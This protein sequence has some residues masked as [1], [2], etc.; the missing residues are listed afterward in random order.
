MPLPGAELAEEGEVGIVAVEI[1]DV[2]DEQGDLRFQGG[3]EA[4]VE[5]GH[6]GEGVEEI[7]VVEI[8]VVEREVA[9]EAG[10]VA[11]H[12][13]EGG[14]ELED[15]SG[16]G[17]EPGVEVRLQV[18]EDAVEPRG[19]GRALVRAEQAGRRREL[20]DD[21]ELL[22]EQGQAGLVGI[23]GRAFHSAGVLQVRAE[24]LS[25]VGVEG[26]GLRGSVWAATLGR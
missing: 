11:D 15:P 7:S 5:L 18:L 8:M 17:V 2:V 20:V 6:G 26:L 1:G 10:G 12:G 3:D 22:A 21:D 13:I 16:C 24:P 25:G 4:G 14:V 9:A 23:V 19:R